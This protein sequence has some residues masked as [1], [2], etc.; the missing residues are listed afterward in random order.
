MV[1]TGGDYVG[2]DK[3]ADEDGDDDSAV[4]CFFALQLSCP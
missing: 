4:F 3:G 1:M 2:N